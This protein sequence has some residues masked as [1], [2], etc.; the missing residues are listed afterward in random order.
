M[1]H[2]KTYESN[3]VLKKYL[4]MHVKMHD[5]DE[6]HIT[7]ATYGEN[8]HNPIYNINVE[9]VVIYFNKTNTLKK[10]EDVDRKN[11]IGWSKYE[12]LEPMILFQSDSFEDCEKELEMIIKAKE[13]NI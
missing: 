4:L 1:K 12:T 2:L 11:T 8:T 7:K 6:I 5:I 10:L 13:Y 9:Q 3:D